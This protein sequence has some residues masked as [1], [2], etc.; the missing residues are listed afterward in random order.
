VTEVVGEGVL[1]A[2]IAR[3]EADDVGVERREDVEVAVSSPLKEV[4][5]RRA[6]VLTTELTT[7]EGG[8]KGSGNERRKILVEAVV[9]G[10][11][12]GELCDD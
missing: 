8:M 10:T 2:V 11:G 12:V 1:L 3:D 5:S 9:V 7:E 4:G 6:R